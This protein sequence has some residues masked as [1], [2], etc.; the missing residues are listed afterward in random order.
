MYGKF[1]WYMSKSHG[2]GWSFNIESQYF[3][4]N[5]RLSV[6]LSILIYFFEFPASGI[7]EL[8]APIVSGQRIFALAFK[9]TRYLLN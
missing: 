5:E 6:R 3:L 4:S 2:N 1:S 9:P 7:N 8:C